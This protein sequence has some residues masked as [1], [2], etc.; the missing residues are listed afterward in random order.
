MAS[1]TEPLYALPIVL[2]GTETLT[3][4]MGGGSTTSSFVA[5][6]TA[7]T[8]YQHD[9]SFGDQVASDLDDDDDHAGASWAFSTAGSGLSWRGVLART[10]GQSGDNISQIVVSEGLRKAL[11]WPS[12]TLTTS[13]GI[14]NAAPN[15]T[16][17]GEYQLGHLWLPRQIQ[18]Y[19]DA[20][21]QRLVAVSETPAGGASVDS[22]G[23]H[24]KWMHEIHWVP[25]ALVKRDF[26]ADSQ[27]VAAVSGLQAG[28]NTAPLE[29][30]WE[31]LGTLAGGTP[32]AIK[33]APDSANPTTDVETLYFQDAEQLAEL[34]NVAQKQNDAPLL[35]R[36]TLRLTEVA[37]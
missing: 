16:I 28:D 9:D 12:T 23:G 21:P 15:T 11:G 17:T 6:M 7:G 20:L 29:T 5:T 33:Y 19:R 10:S 37:S 8:Y 30:W 26:A 2:D 3:V 32:P 25:A 1:F 35:Y 22:Y 4:T 18:T 31:L 34:A 36:V 13:N 24:T 27:Y 14:A